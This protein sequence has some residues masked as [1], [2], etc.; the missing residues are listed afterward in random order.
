MKQAIIVIGGYNSLWPIYLRMARD[1]ERLA[2]L[3]AV[4][5][6]LMPWDWWAAH[7]AKDATVVLQKLEGTGAWARRRLQAERLILVGHSAGG[8]IGRLYLSEQPVWAR[9][10]NGVRYV[11]ALITLGSPHCTARGD[12]TGWYLSDQANRL[13]PGAFYADRMAYYAVVGRYTQGRLGGTL[14]QRRAYRSYAFFG[15]QS[16]A[17]GDGIVPLDCARLDGAEQVILDGVG[18]SRKTGPR[19]YGGSPAIVRR[20]WPAGAVRA[21]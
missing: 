17:W 10:Y 20:W 14:L 13:V 4:G 19:W 18:H 2:G 5:V 6:P 21:E 7:R 12:K 8:V 1:L 15:A 3:P 9:V 16:A 11:D